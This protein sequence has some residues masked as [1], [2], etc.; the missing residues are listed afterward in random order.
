MKYYQAEMHCHTKEVSPCS[1]IPANYLI[2]GY[3]EAGYRY[4]FTTDHYHPDVFETP[5]L[6]RKSWDKKIDHFWNGFETA[7]KSAQGTYIT[8]LCGME[9]ALGI[10]RDSGL[11][12]DFL[13]YGFTKEFLLDEPN[14]YELNYQDFYQKMKENGFLVFQAH[15]YRYGLTPVEPVC[16]DGV[17]MVNTHPRHF[18]RNKLAIE[19]AATHDLLVIGGSDAH[20]E[21]D[22]GRGGVMLPCGIQSEQ[23]FVQYI[24]ENG[25][26]ELIVTFGA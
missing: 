18:S 1:R 24:K 23:D 4:V 15:P 13:V 2:E 11:G 9:V 26:P 6:K 16:Y 5:K 22:V 10:D 17:E 3:K 8:V 14:L 21:E 19:F 25:S 7:K 12:S 20:S